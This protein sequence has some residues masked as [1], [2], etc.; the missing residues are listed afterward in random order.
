MVTRACLSLLLAVLTS[1]SPVLAQV[2][3]DTLGTEAPEA[4]LLEGL[5]ETGDAEELADFLEDLRANPLDLNAARA[6]ELA[7]LPSLSPLLATRIVAYRDSTGGFASLPALQ[8]VPG[9][10]P[11]IYASVRP[12]LRLGDVLDVVAR[13]ASRFPAVP[14]RGAWREVRG[15]AIQ[16][17]AR[18][19]ETARGYAEGRYAGSPDRLYTRLRVTSARH[20]SAN[21]TLEKDPGEAFGWRPED[22]TFGYDYVSAHLAIANIGRVRALVAGDFTASF[23]QGLVLW[24]SAALGKSAEATRGLSRFGSGVRPYG[25]T[26]ENR[27]FRGAAATVLLTPDLALT[28][29]FSRRTLDATLLD[30]DTGGV[31]AFGTSGLHR[32]DSEIARKDALGETVSGGAVEL[33]RRRFRVGAAYVSTWFDQPIV[34]REAPDARFAFRGRSGQATSVFGHLFLGNAV[35]FGEAA[36]GGDGTGLVGGAEYAIGRTGEVVVLG[37]HYARDFVSLHGYAFGER[38]GA[39][40]NEQGLYVGL[41]LRPRRTVTVQGY[42]DQYR[43]PWLRF[44]V[45]RPTHGYDTR[46][47]VTHAPRRWLAQEVS[48]RSETREAGVTLPDGPR[49]VAAVRPETRQSLRWQGTYVFSNRLTLR[50]RAEGVRFA[51]DGAADAYGLLLFQDVRVRPFDALTLDLRLAFYDTDGYDARVYAYEYDVRYGF[52]VPPLYGRGVRQYVVA[53]WQPVRALLVEARYAVT[54]REDVTTL[55]SGLDETDGNRAREVKAQVIW[56]F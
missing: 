54:H 4:A 41:R 17:Y 31:S 12:Y 48:L 1:A 29:F 5:A 40:Q 15:Q 25:S 38:V 11:E 47:T 37:R 30:A 36:R 27:F 44:N 35:L 43:F 24:R 50:A 6:D 16:R 42:F 34:P 51:P 32:L 8:L 52:S 20:L 55:G 3:P 13:R 45:P 26:D 9:I 39:T 53:R 23:G 33:V 19:L 22:G 18:R 21:L 14:T 49:T 7:L 28:A 56:T 10:T 2:T 46:L